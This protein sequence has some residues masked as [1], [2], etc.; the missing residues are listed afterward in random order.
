M[1]RDLADD[2]TGQPDARDDRNGA[3]TRPGGLDNEE[4]AGLAGANTLF[5]ARQ[6]RDRVDR[7][8]T[9][10]DDALACVVHSGRGVVPDRAGEHD[11]HY[12]QAAGRRQPATGGDS[13]SRIV[14]PQKL[15]QSGCRQ[16]GPTWPG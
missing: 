5:G 10:V 6:I 14:W 2:G 1:A 13:H 12:D 8:R 16:L 9:R 11:E 4:I 7:G 3:A 15:P